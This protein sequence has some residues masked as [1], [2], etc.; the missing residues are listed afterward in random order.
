MDK[1]SLRANNINWVN[2]KYNTFKVEFEDIDDVTTSIMI[3]Y[4][5][6]I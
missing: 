1:R 3:N 2:S 6:I 4:H 5:K